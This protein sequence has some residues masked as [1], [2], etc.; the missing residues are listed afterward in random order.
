MDAAPDYH[1]RC[2]G[3]ASVRAWGFHI[4]L[5]RALLSLFCPLQCVRSS[6]GVLPSPMVHGRRGDIAPCCRR[7]A[8]LELGPY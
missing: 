7:P 4:L 5:Q 2:P 1:G 6:P 3:S 8:T